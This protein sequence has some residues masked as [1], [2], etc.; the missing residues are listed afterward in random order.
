MSREQ[1]EEANFLIKSADPLQYS[2]SFDVSV[3]IRLHRPCLTKKQQGREDLSFTFDMIKGIGN[4]EVIFREPLLVELMGA[5][6]TK[7]QGS[8]VFKLSF[9]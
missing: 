3:P 5:G 6:F 2:T 9:A 8:K 7:A 4:P 1:L